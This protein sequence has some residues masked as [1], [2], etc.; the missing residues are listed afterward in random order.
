MQ[1]RVIAFHD[2]RS[3]ARIPP[4]LHQDKPAAARDEL[5]EL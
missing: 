4:C 5:M 3:V 1:L 2:V